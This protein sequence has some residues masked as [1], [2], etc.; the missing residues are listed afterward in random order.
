MK[1]EIKKL[2]SKILKLSEQMKVAV[3][4]RHIFASLLLDSKIAELN[5]QK[6][7]IKEYFKK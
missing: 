1:E 2:N 5:R 6:E 3:I 7:M 4:E